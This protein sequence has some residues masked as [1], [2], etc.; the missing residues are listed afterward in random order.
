MIAK[1]QTVAAETLAADLTMIASGITPTPSPVS[2]LDPD[3]TIPLLTATPTIDPNEENPD[4]T[5]QGRFVED[6]T[7]PDG[8]VFQPGE[9]FVKTWRL[10]NTGT[11]VWTSGYSVIFEE[12]DAMGGPA[13]FQISAGG[14]QPE[15]EAD[16]SVTLTAPSESGTYRGDWKLRDAA[17]RVFGLGSQKEASFWVLIKVGDALDFSLSYATTHSCGEVPHAIIRIVNESG[18]VLESGEISLYNLTTDSNLFGPL[19]HDGPFMANASECPPGGSAIKVGKTMY[20]G[21]SLGTPPPSG[22]SVRATI[23]ICTQDSLRGTCNEES[24]TFTVP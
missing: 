1:T 18:Q 2:T 9:S 5:N 6:V 16:V 19:A 15:Q 10:E 22:A 3:S 20:M 4:C 8:E 13:S 21:A 23:K 24:L 11:C 14:V 12:G 7:I 17:G